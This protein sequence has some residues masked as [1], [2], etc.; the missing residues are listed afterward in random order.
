MRLGPLVYIAT[1]SVFAL[2]GIYLLMRQQAK[3]NRLQTKVDWLMARAGTPTVPAPAPT[4]QPA[5]PTTLPPAQQTPPEQTPPEQTPLPPAPAPFPE[6]APQP[7]AERSP[8]F[9]G[10]PAPPRASAPAPSPGRLIIPVQG[11]QPKDLVDTYTQSRGQGRK[12]DA[13]DIIAPRG[14]PVLAVADGTVLKLFRSKA[15]GITLYQLSADGTAIYYYAHLERYAPGMAEGKALRQGEEIA[16]VGDSGNVVPG[17]THLHFEIKTTRNPK[18]F[19]EGINVN[20]F[21][22]LRFDMNRL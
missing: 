9:I 17:N 7:P 14:T 20:P 2:G 10:P 21:P 16:Y 8:S 18:R 13:I 11:I 19:W 12:H 6:P 3:I 22:L 5:P 15:G 4:A 1:T